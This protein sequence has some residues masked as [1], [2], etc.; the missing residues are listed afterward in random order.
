METRHEWNMT[1]GTHV[2]RQ[3]RFPPQGDL[4]FSEEEGWG[5]WGRVCMSREGT[6][7][8]GAAIGM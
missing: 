1:Q 7:R 8:V 5:R 2:H 6:G 3:D 4:P